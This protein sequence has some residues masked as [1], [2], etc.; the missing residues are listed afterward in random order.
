MT[1]ISIGVGVM[2][3]VIITVIVDQQKYQ[4]GLVRD[5]RGKIIPSPPEERLYVGMI[6]AFLLPV[7]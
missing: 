6:G 5:G 2:I 3:G 4:K 1:F 7:G